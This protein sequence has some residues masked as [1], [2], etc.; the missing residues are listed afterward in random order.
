MESSTTSSDSF[1]LESAGLIVPASV[2]QYL[3]SIFKQ[4]AELFPFVRLPQNI[5][6]QVMAETRPFLLLAAVTAAAYEYPKMQQVLCS[7]VKQIIMETIVGDGESNLD[8]L[9]GLLVHLAW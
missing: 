4:M 2:L 1:L 7:E 9:Q 3:T 5:S 6:L 8:L